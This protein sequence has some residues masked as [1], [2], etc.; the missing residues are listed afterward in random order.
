M[1]QMR[2][3][4]KICHGQKPNL[5]QLLTATTISVVKSWVLVP[6]DVCLADQTL[7]I[8]VNYRNFL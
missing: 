3:Q 5:S 1:F 4:K 6:R 8:T 7:S 2:L